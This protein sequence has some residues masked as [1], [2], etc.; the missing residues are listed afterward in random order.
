MGCSHTDS[1][2]LSTLKDKEE[3][4]MKLETPASFHRNV[5]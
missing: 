4:I 5:D 2:A 3:K 1:V